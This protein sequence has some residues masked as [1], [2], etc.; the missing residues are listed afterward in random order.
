MPQQQIQWLLIFLPDKT[1]AKWKYPPL[2]LYLKSKSFK[3]FNIKKKEKSTLQTKYK[4]N[5]KQ[6]R[7]KKKKRRLEYDTPG[8]NKCITMVALRFLKG[9]YKY[10]K[11]WNTDAEGETNFIMN[12]IFALGQPCVELTFISNQFISILHITELSIMSQY[13]LAVHQNSLV[14]KYHKS[15]KGAVF[16]NKSNITQSSSSLLI[17]ETSF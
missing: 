8:S 5:Y 6:H 12:H 14:Q 4:Y 16:I 3:N 15:L 1:L 17:S 7:K 2:Y 10:M 9:G 11:L 13:N